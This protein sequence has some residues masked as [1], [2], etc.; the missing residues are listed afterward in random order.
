MKRCMLILLSCTVL[1]TATNAQEMNEAKEPT[2]EVKQPKTFIKANIISPI[3]KNYGFQLEQV[4][5]KRVSIAVGYRTMPNGNLP[6]KSNIVASSGGST[7]TQEALDALMLQNTAITP[8]IRFYMGKKGYGRGFYMAPFFRSANYKVEG[9]SFDYTN[10]SNVNSSIALSGELKTATFGLQLG[11]QWS[12]G[13]NVCLDW[14]ILGPHYGN[15]K[16]SMTGKSSQ[17]L[18]ATEQSS[19][20]TELNN[21]SV[22]LADVSHTVNASGATINISGPWAGI[23]A[24]LMLGIKF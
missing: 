24:G 8:E 14:W 9:L 16:G 19:L 5:S 1:L 2:S 4:L 10:A 23:K 20:N 13:K 15:A 7:S 3:I 18:S 6:F 11:A 21:F 12:I 22:P 17:P